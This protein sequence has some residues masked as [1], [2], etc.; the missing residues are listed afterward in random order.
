MTAPMTAPS[1]APTLAAAFAPP[2][3]H[4][5]DTLGPPCAEAIPLPELLSAGRFAAVATRYAASFPGGETRAALSLWS[6]YYLL[7]LVPGAVAAAL[8]LRRDLPLALDGMG[9][10]L[11]GE[12]QPC[13]LCLPHDGC[14]TAET[15]P[16]RRLAPLLRTHLLPLSA[17]L[18]IAGLPP[19]VFWSN[20][21]A[22]LAWSLGVIAA[23]ADDRDAVRVA[24]AAP[25]WGDDEP[26]P[27]R[28]V[29]GDDPARRRVCCLRVRLRCVARCPDCPVAARRAGQ[30]IVTHS[31]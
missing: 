30:T 16:V 17:A 12:G 23:P 9:A 8:S 20:A 31:S 14:D 28:G 26:N 19:P 1:A 11:A 25:R 10:L 3:A 6:Q 24:L 13:R 7:A 5:G 22:V 29:V 18:T 4:F 21:A 27:F 2:F 15:C